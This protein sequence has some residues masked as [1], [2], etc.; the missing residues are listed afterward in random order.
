MSSG[1]KLV[2]LSGMIDAL[3]ERSAKEMLS[4][5]SCPLNEDVETFLKYKAIEFSKQCL[6]QT[7]LVYSSYKKEEVLVGYFTIANKY[8]IVKKDKVSKTTY[9][10]L[11]KFG[12][13]I[14]DLKQISI[15]APLIGQLGKNFNGGY[16]KLITGDELLGIALEQVE[17][18]LKIIG[19]QIVYLECE[20]N[21]R[22]VDFYGR[23][24]FKEF[25]RRPLDRDETNIKGQYLIQML[26][27]M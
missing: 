16:N 6:S 24:G 1:Y 3:G 8:I 13:E 4:R 23:N 19:G 27:I 14:P 2:T 10:R 15:A 21:T 5:F 11:S 7:T 20:D 18:A 26:K 25:D 9:K 12:Q 17:I 22:L